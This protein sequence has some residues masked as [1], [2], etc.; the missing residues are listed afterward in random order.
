MRDDTTGAKKVGNA[1]SSRTVGYP[2]AVGV[3]VHA[4]E[5]G[6]HAN[7]LDFYPDPHFIELY[8]LGGWGDGARGL[9]TAPE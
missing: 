3:S 6:V 7:E 5:G 2:V 9:T 8:S 4:K 1:P